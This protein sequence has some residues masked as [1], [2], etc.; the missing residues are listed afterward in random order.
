[1]RPPWD[2]Y[3]LLSPP[4]S[5]LHNT[6][7]S[8]QN[9]HDQ[10]NKGLILRKFLYCHRDWYRHLSNI[11]GQYKAD[12]DYDQDCNLHSKY[13]KFV[14]SLEPT[15][16]N[17]ATRPF[18]VYIGHERCLTYFCFWVPLWLHFSDQLHSFLIP[19]KHAVSE[20][21]PFQTRN[22]PV[23]WFDLTW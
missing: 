12:G 5:S 19:T 16:V 14:Q 2:N 11:G 3:Y 4:T 15:P 1:M 17:F 22:D 20:L 13:H 21:R 7:C 8:K 6:W 23:F 10:Q 9:F 18:R